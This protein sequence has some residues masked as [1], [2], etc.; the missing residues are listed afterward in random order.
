M[1]VWKCWW[2]SLIVAQFRTAKPA[3]MLCV[4]GREL[5]FRME[6]E[7]GKPVNWDVF[8]VPWLSRLESHAIIQFRGMLSGDCCNVR[9]DVLDGQRLIEGVAGG[10][11]DD[12]V[13]EDDG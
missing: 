6:M 7:W 1:K 13:M 11:E 5:G 10:Q 12:D 8:D 4:Y 9:D 3:A 2:G